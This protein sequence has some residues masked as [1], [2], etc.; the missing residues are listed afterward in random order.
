VAMQDETAEYMASPIEYFRRRRRYPGAIPT[1]LFGVP[2]HL[3]VGPEAHEFV[4]VSHRQLFSHAMGYF[5][6]QQTFG[7][8]HLPKQTVMLALDGE[9]WRLQH[10]LMLPL[11]APAYVKRALE[12]KKELYRERMAEWAELG[13]VDL[14]D[15]LHSLTLQGALKGLFGIELGGDAR[16]VRGLIQE[17]ATV[18]FVDF[19]TESALA[20]AA[21]AH[22]RLTVL[23][24]PH[25]EA[26]R[27][28][29]AGDGLSLYAADTTVAGRLMNDAEIMSCLAG[30]FF[31]AH[32]TTKSLMTFAFYFMLRYSGYAARVLEEAEQVDAVDDLSFEQ[33]ASPAALPVLDNLVK[34]TE[35]MYPP[36]HLHSRGVLETFEFGGREI[37]KG[38]IVH[39]APIATHYD[40]S[41]Y[42]DPE[43][44]DPDRFALP[45]SEDSFSQYALDAF[46]GGMRIC[47]GRPLARMDIKQALLHAFRNYRL[48]RSDDS[49]IEVV[50]GPDTYPRNGLKVTVRRFAA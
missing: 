26:K 33:L 4:H 29:P 25:I 50:W 8:P 38:S 9:D 7:G 36:L 49:E 19:G 39:V 10:R 20:R 5:R 15:E 6:V 35:R 43:I 45:R 2:C 44:F 14:L 34:E 46:G 18:A 27:R 37:A 41:F 1:V 32:G 22:R 31:A 40:P 28:H 47:I 24:A 13:T 48:R 11:F 30:L 3:M 12:V 16:E 23:M 21:A 42:K 17:L